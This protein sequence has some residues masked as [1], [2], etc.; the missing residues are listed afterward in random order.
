MSDQIILD[1]QVLESLR[2]AIGDRTQ[3][4]ISLY[5]SE[6]PK[7]IQE[8]QQAAARGDYAAARI[9]VHALKSSSASLGAMA[10]SQISAAIEQKLIKQDVNNL[11]QELQG[12]QKEF[13]QVKPLFGEFL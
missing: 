8:A 10:V 2:Q 4:I 3:H 6:A 13:D 1:K 7:N 9:I 12:L 11:T 5:L